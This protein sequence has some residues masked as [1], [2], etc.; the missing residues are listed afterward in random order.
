MFQK[1]ILAVTMTFTLNLLLEI[2]PP[3]LA[4]ADLITKGDVAQI[5]KSR[6][7]CLLSVSDK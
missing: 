3:V 2:R 5:L 1:L 4:Q 6:I 7:I